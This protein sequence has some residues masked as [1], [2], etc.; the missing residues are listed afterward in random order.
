VVSDRRVPHSSSGVI[1]YYT[2]DI[3]S[4]NDY[5]PFGM[6]MPGRNF[7]GNQY[8]F[9]FNGKE[10]DPEG[11]GG[12]GST[13]DYGFRIYNPQIAKF[14]SVDPL[15]KSYPWYTPYQFAGN[16]PIQALDLDG[17]EILD[18]RSSY[19]IEI[20]NSPLLYKGQKVI[21]AL[22][23]NDGSFTPQFFKSNAMTMGDISIANIEAYQ[24]GII[25][26]PIRARIDE[27]MNRKREQERVK[28]KGVGKAAQF[29]K[30]NNNYKPG[31]LNAFAWIIEKLAIFGYND[32]QK[33]R[34]NALEDYN[35]MI[36]AAK[37][38]FSVVSEVISKAKS[39]I[40]NKYNNFVKN[41]GVTEEKLA[42]D[43]AQYIMD[44]TFD[45]PYD[46]KTQTKKYNYYNDKII[47]FGNAIIKS[48]KEVNLKKKKKSD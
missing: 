37:L 23:V 15:F 43:L 25:Y 44:G 1:N 6:P 34:D 33:S 3:V 27:L 22:A 7:S 14:L 42:T 26:D 18:Y 32:S 46:K 9:G 2:A 19:R 30:F 13:Y 48:H 16:T 24:G 31:N 36:N 29:V 28:G 5:Y 10:K 17:L 11:M 41:L 39:T 45:N 4:S 20:I 35:N 21:S 38:A 47:G 12:G 8:R 40:P